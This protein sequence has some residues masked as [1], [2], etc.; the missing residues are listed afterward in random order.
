MPKPI[1]N[2]IDD[3]EL[4]KNICKDGEYLVEKILK[5]KI[6]E[7]KPLFYVK[8]MGIRFNSHFSH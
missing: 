7:K 8:W 5:K 3:K 6:K 1:S 4:M 2:I